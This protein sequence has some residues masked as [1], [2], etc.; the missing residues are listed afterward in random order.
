MQNLYIETDKW[1]CIGTAQIFFHACTGW[2]HIFSLIPGT[3]PV[4]RVSSSVTA[5][6]K[7]QFVTPN[8]QG[9]SQSQKYDVSQNVCEHLTFP[10]W[11]E[12][13]TV[14]GQPPDSHY[15]EGTGDGEEDV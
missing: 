3:V 8:F 1:H 13:P 6:R 10:Q 7:I 11:K 5:S 12:T 2:D 9:F 4:L 14:V 15:Q